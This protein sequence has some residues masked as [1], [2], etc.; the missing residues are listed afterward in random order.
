MELCCRKH[1]GS[2][3]PWNALLVNQRHLELKHRVKKNV[4]G[5]VLFAKYCSKSSAPEVR[6]ADFPKEKVNSGKETA[7]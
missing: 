7:C 4:L 6:S 5:C 1:P 2:V 3:L